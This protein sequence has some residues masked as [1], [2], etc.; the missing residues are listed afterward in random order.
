MRAPSSP[1]LLLAVLPLPRQAHAPPPRAGRSSCPAAGHRAGPRRPRGAPP[2]RPRQARARSTPPSPTRRPL[3]FPLPARHRGALPAERALG[4]H[5]YFSQPVH[6]NPER[7]DTAIRVIVY[8]TS[9]TAP[10]GAGGAPHRGAAAGRGRVPVG[11]RP[12]VLRN[13]GRVARVA[14]DSARPSW[15]RCR[16]RPGTSDRR[17]ARATLARR[18]RPARATRSW[19]WRRSRRGRSS[20]RFEYVSVRPG[21]SSFRWTAGGSGQP[22]GGGDG[23]RVSGGTLA[24]AD[25]QVIEGRTSGAVPGCAG[26]RRGA[27]CAAAVPLARSPLLACPPCWWAASRWCCRSRV[28]AARA[29]V[30]GVPAPAP[31]SC[32]MPSP[33]STRATRDARARPRRTSGGAYTGG[34]GAAQGGARGALAAGGRTDRLAPQNNRSTRTGTLGNR[35][36]TGAAPPL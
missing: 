2:G 20:S 31:G 16:C 17:W 9:T 34:A 5:R 4:R 26:R 33:R 11:A 21:T 22:A 32:S 27:I 18:R 12:D 30:R 3:P 28:A 6:T 14:P 36:N 1:S 15:R 10:I 19:C 8:D 24:L 29:S 7:P 35:C 23:R 25:S 13:D